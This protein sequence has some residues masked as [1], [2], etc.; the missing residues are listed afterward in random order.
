MVEAGLLQLIQPHCRYYS[1]LFSTED[2][3]WL[4]NKTFGDSVKRLLW[5]SKICLDAAYLLNASL[6]CSY[7]YHLRLEDDT[8]PYVILIIHSLN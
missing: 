4:K 3:C 5:R 2:L 1:P 8:P 7:K 6:Q